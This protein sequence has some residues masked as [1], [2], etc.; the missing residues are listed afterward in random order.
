MAFARFCT[1]LART[2]VDRHC[3]YSIHS[4]TCRALPAGQASGV[5]PAALQ[6]LLQPSTHVTLYSSCLAYH[7]ASSAA[8]TSHIC[9]KMFSKLCYAPPAACAQAL[10]ALL[11]PSPLTMLYFD[12][13]TERCKL[14]FRMSP[15]PATVLCL[16]P[17]H[18]ACSTAVTY[19]N[20]KNG[21]DVLCPTCHLRQALQAL[22]QPSFICY[23]T[24]LPAAPPAASCHMPP[25][26]ATVLGLIAYRAAG[27]AAETKVVI[28]GIVQNAI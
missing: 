7:A 12:C 25:S 28:E 26:P 13:C 6:A 27:S 22:L 16:I 3:C 5:A 9:Y 8:V 15:S 24:L 2:E 18:A 10:L 19:S 1:V 11:Q 14:P 4:L 23:A 21:Q 20:K 17:Y